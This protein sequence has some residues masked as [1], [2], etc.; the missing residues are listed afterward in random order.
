MNP[1][2]NR[3]E[4]LA[5]PKN[6]QSN[7]NIAPQFLDQR[8]AGTS[9]SIGRGEGPARNTSSFKKPKKTKD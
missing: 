9:Y 5:K 2:V 4:S 6:Y 8:G 7:L 3:Q 1:Y